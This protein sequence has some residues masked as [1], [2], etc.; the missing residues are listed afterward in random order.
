MTAPLFLLDTDHDD[1]PVLAEGFEQGWTLQLPEHVRRHAIQAMR[2]NNGDALQLSDGK[3][4][5]VACTMND[6]TM[7]S[8]SVDHFHREPR[9]L[10]RLSLVQALAKNGHD[11]QAI[12]IATQIG[13]DEVIP[14]CADRSIAKWKPGRTDKRWSQLLR[15]SC[16]QSRRAWIPE[17][18]DCVNSKQL[19]AVCRRACVHGDLVVVLHQDA[20]DR[21]HQ[22]E[23]A[24][25]ELTER[26][27][28]DGRER[29]IYVVVGPEGGI[30][31]Q[32]ITSLIDAGA[33]SC[34]L[35]SNILRA[36]SAGAVALS[37]FSRSLGRYD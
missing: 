24:V 21:L 12:D 26:C 6:T 10:T 14:W 2:L 33:K 35:G 30:S 1:A 3:G 37:L 7:G 11:E 18:Q 16:E 23:Q 5:R 29:T 28:Q 15:A 32:E 9:V 4:L 13:V 8:V 27:L 25:N 22:I 17:L 31:D 36:S 34:V 19:L 20:T